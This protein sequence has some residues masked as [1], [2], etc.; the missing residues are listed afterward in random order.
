MTPCARVARRLGLALWFAARPLLAASAMIAAGLQAGALAA[1]AVAAVVILVRPLRRGWIALVACAVLWPLAPAAVA[2]LAGRLVLGEL[3][4]QLLGGGAPGLALRDRR[5]RGVQ[6]ACG[7]RRRLLG[8]FDVETA[9]SVDEAVRGLDGLADTAPTEAE[10][11]LAALAVLGTA[12]ADARPLELARR[13]PGTVVMILAGLFSDDPAGEPRGGIGTTVAQAYIIET[14]GPWL[15]A[16]AVLV[17]AAL[18]GAL[19]FPVDPVS[20]GPLELGGSVAQGLAILIVGSLAC[21][22][23][24]GLTV[25]G[26]LV[27][28]LVLGPRALEMTLIVAVVAIVNLVGRQAVER[29]ALDGRRG[30]PRSEPVSGPRRLRSQWRAAAAAAEAGRLPVAIDI[31]EDLTSRG[32]CPAPLRARA[33]ARLALHLFAVGRLEDA[34][35]AL[36]RVPAGGSQDPEHLLALGTVAMGTGDLHGAEAHL[37]AS[38]KQLRRGSPLAH[39]ATRTLAQVV[40]RLDRPDDAIAL[41]AESRANAWS[42]GG[43]ARVVEG[44][45]AIAAAL[46]RRGDLA[47]AA[48]RLDEAIDFA[49]IDSVHAVDLGRELRRELARVEA[50]ARLVAGETALARGRHREAADYLKGIRSRIQGGREAHLVACADALHGT[51]LIFAGDLR[52]G[53][54]NA[55]RGIEALEARRRQLRR[56]D[57]RTGLILAEGELYDWCLSAFAHAA[58]RGLADAAETAAWLI[59]SLRKSAI[60]SM[61]RDDKLELP[62]AATALAD[63]ISELETRI[64]SVAADGTTRSAALGGADLDNEIAHLRGQLGD[65]LSS[66]FARSYV[67]APTS[68]EELRAIARECGDV[69]SFYLPGGDLPGWRAWISA[70]G[71]FTIDRVSVADGEA[72]EVLDELRAGGGPRLLSAIYEPVRS[73][74]ITRVWD[75]LGRSLLPAALRTMLST[76]DDERPRALLVVPDGLLGLLPWAAVQ[77]D[78]APLG[79]RCTI[80]VV[81]SLGLVDGEADAAPTG[82]EPT[83]LAYFDESL[84][85]YHEE[86]TVLSHHLSVVRARSRREFIEALAHGRPGGAYLAAHGLGLGL[87]QGIAFDDGFLS[88]GTALLSRWPAWTIFASCLV[89]RVP[90]TAGQ[91]PL[92]LPISCVLGGSRSVLAAMAEVP[93]EDMAA[94]VAPLLAELARGGSPAHALLCAQRRYLD[95]H[96]YASVADCLAFVCVSRAPQ[97]VSDRGMIAAVPALVVDEAGNADEHPVRVRARLA[98]AVAAAPDDV[99][100]WARYAAFLDHHGASHARTREAYECLLELAP[101]HAWAIERFARFLLTQTDDHATAVAM[102]ERALRNAPDS[103]AAAT[104]LADALQRVGDFGRAQAMYERALTLEPDR[105]DTGARLGGVIA[106]RGGDAQRVANLFERAIAR[107]PDRA[108]RHLNAWAL[109]ALRYRD[110][111]VLAERLLRRATELAPDD[112]TVAANLAWLVSDSANATGPD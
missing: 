1:V 54:A 10:F 78:G 48:H 28:W 56:S 62:A 107:E 22:R 61:L 84:P 69:L 64:N 4:L 41:V 100:A 44:E 80:Q 11:E 85:G 75:A 16:P 98:G 76:Q 43:I 72:R 88:A 24:V 35:A 45:T 67:P 26:A 14:L 73:G 55:R 77:V 74:A 3:A 102:Q 90:M 20:I 105:R 51:A 66:Q 86:H 60:S 53:L 104:A 63:R 94:F 50:S 32:A 82:A 112:A 87:E 65:A 103:A 81:P 46:R 23:W 29:F 52:E 2:W 58:E 79:Q 99:D 47:V 6:A 59:E 18:V 40:S 17:P 25:V 49:L 12:W 15:V 19:V 91:E 7:P 101:D 30:T 109:A 36:D 95:E 92:G 106:R 97:R 5:R 9:A 108:S 42:H 8:R 38:L 96:P 57:R 37:R 83:A 21:A 110:D 39:Q 13:V 31:L 71:G 34:S 70:S 89:G 111:R 93:S 68:V 33:D 27:A